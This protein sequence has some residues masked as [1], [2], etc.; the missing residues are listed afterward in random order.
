MRDQVGGTAVV[1]MGRIVDL[2]DEVGEDSSGLA[3]WCWLRFKGD[4]GTITYFATGYFPRKAESKAKKTGWYQ[5]KILYESKGDFRSPTTIFQE[6]LLA[7]LESW[8]TK[9]YKVILAIDA[10]QHVYDGILAKALAEPPFLM[11]CALKEVIGERVPKSWHRG[12]DPISTIFSSPGINVTNAM[13]YPHYMGVGD[14][15]MFCIEVTS[16]S[17]FGG[18]FP[19]VMKPISRQLNCRIPRTSRKYREHLLAQVERHSMHRRMDE[20]FSALDTPHCTDEITSGH[21]KWDQELGTYMANAENKCTVYRDCHYEFSPEINLLLQ[22]RNVLRWMKRHFEGKVPHVCRL[23][24]A[25]RSVGLPLPDETTEDEV[26]V[27]L[28]VVQSEL[29]QL[30][31][32]APSMR[33]HFLQQ[34]LKLAKERGDED[35]EREIQRILKRESDRRK[36]Q[37]INRVVKA[38]KGRSVIKVQLN[39]PKTTKA[40][41]AEYRTEE[42]DI[43]RGCNS[44]LGSRFQLGKRAPMTQDDL[45]REDFGGIADT[46][47]ATAVLSGSYIPHDGC[48]NATKLL[49]REISTL[50]SLFDGI[51]P[52]RAEISMDDFID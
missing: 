32:S 14:H 41:D 27:R 11:E 37:R 17:L 45:L 25:C 47:A 4:D 21:E 15:R 12:K 34:Q 8:R 44:R 48:D 18:V 29:R 5:H 10:N 42:L 36:Q 35:D 43:V 16:E 2:V 9:G 23:I 1:A 7:Q 30:R 6:D 24:R 26:K 33:R 49:L 52:G 28:E 39:D 3:R 20:L 38:P 22:H 19:T 31:E 40:E 46:P 50:N 13:A 51:D